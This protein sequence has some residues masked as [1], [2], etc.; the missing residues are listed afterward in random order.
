VGLGLGEISNQLYPEQE[1]AKAMAI[2]GIKNLLGFNEM[3]LHSNLI[4]HFCMRNLPIEAA[5]KRNKGCDNWKAGGLRV[6][7]NLI[8]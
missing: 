1:S 8:I 2:K 3:L 7:S 6:F 4:N 5:L